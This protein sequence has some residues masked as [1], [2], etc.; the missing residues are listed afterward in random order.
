ML[1]QKSVQV[2]IAEV[3]IAHTEMWFK[4]FALGEYLALAEYFVIS[5]SLLP[6]TLRLFLLDSVGARFDSC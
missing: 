4:D 1:L 3:C 2:V 6:H 5:S